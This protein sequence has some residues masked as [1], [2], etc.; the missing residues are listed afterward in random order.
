MPEEVKTW[1]GNILT[2]INKLFTHFSKRRAVSTI[3]LCHQGI[4]LSRS[5]A[6]LTLGEEGVDKA[7][8]WH[9]PTHWLRLPSV[10]CG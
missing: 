2:P 3:P 6:I 8:P 7:L 4:M 5:E 9:Q 1:C 10:G